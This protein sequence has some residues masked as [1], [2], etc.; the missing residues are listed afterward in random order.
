MTDTPWV[1]IER[2]AS[3]MYTLPDPNDPDYV[4]SPWP[5]RHPDDHA[6]WMAYAKAAI[7]AMP[8]LEE[9]VM[10]LDYNELCNLSGLAQSEVGR[11]NMQARAANGEDGGGW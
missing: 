1:L 7:N 4:P 3:A 10:A 11:R 5:P 9:T 2:V 6:M 8:P